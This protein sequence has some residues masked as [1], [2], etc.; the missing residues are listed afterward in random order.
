MQLL[1]R[2]VDL[3][4]N[5]PDYAARVNGTW[6]GGGSPELGSRGSATPAMA[7]LGHPTFIRDEVKPWRMLAAR[8]IH[9]GDRCGGLGL[10][11]TLP[12]KRAARGR[13]RTVRYGSGSS[14]GCTSHGSAPARPQEPTGGSR[15]GKRAQEGAAGGGGGSVRAKPTRDSVLL[16]GPAYKSRFPP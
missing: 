8:V 14:S 3:R 16:T 5:G 12:T 10:G 15:T 9:L 7:D 11:S 1:I 13:R 6:S 2:R 4:S